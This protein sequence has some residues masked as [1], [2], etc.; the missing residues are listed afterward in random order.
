MQFRKKPFTT[1]IYLAQLSLDEG[2]ALIQPENLKHPLFFNGERVKRDYSRFAVL[3]SNKLACCF[4]GINGTHF[5]LEKHKNDKV[6][7]F[8]VNIYSGSSLLTWDHILPVSH[9]GSDH[10]SNGRIAC[11]PCNEGRGNKLTLE[12]VLWTLKQSPQEI[13]K[14]K[15]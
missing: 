15:Q 12:E 2:L 3:R 14:S 11:S 1:K 7:P 5:L 4:C 9:G 10:V 6:M 13:F 8:Q